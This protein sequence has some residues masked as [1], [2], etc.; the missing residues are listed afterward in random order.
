[1]PDGVS[2]LAPEALCLTEPPDPLLGPDPSYRSIHKRM[3]ETAS[4]ESSTPHTLYFVSD[5]ALFLPHWQLAAHAHSY[6]S[7]GCQFGTP[8][9][10]TL[11]ISFLLHP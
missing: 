7:T 1:M 8:R 6:T 11:M 9:V 5:A 2:S 10:P 4:Q 3:N